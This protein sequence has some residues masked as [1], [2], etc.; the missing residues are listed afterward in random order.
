MGAAA[1][2]IAR[3]LERYRWLSYLGLAIIILV[4]L[5]MI[6]EGGDEVWQAVAVA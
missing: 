3:F 4:A 1:T 6:W 2:V 5:S